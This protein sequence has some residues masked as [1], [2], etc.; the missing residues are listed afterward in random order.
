MSRKQ[1]NLKRFEMGGVT[2]ECLEFTLNYNEI[3]A[4]KDVDDSFFQNPG[5]VHARR[6]C[7]VQEMLRFGYL[8]SKWFF[9]ELISACFDD[10]CDLVINDD[11]SLTLIHS[12]GLIK[13]NFIEIRNVPIPENFH[14]ALE[15]FNTVWN[16]I[17]IR[18]YEPEEPADWRI[19]KRPAQSYQFKT[20]N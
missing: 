19:K 9:D 12:W 7:E 14:D 18:K 4:I 13:E 16:A 3:C 8:I 6:R 2:H 10:W 20:H 5:C 17:L 15:V 11:E 1:E